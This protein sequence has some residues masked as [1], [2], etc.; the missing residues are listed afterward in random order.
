MNESLSEFMAAVKAN[1]IKRMG[2][3][4]GTDRGPAAESMDR[5]VLQRRVTVIQKY[6]ENK[7]YRVVEGPLLVPGHD[8]LRSFKVE[9]QR[10]NCNQVLPIDIV[11]TRSGG[12]LVYDV[13]LESAGNPVGPCQQAGTG[14]RP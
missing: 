1:D 3:L 11:R 6:L 5:A 13:H 4:W 8:E 14:T 7:G 9:L 2:E 10:A 12:W